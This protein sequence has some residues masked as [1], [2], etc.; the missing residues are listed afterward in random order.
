MLSLFVGQ[1]QNGSAFRAFAVSR[2]LSVAEPIMLKH[3][4]AFH[5]LPQ[6]EKGFVFTSALCDILREESKL[7][8]EGLIAEAFESIEKIEI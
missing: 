4:P 6:L 5:R 1:L 8:V 3:E 7:D 2:G